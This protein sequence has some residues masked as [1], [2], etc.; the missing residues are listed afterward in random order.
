MGVSVDDDVEQGS[1]GQLPKLPGRKDDRER[2]E[3]SER[4]D[5]KRNWLT[6]AISL[7]FDVISS[8][9]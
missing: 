6:E 2:L 3:R 5:R 7:I 4:R 9:R 1:D 8:W